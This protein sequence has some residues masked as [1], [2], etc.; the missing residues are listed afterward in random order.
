MTDLAIMS[1]S[2]VRMTRTLTRPASGEITDAFFNAEKPERCWA[3]GSR[4][5][6][7][8]RSSLIEYLRHHTHLV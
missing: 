8:A 6:A 3:V 4:A 5:F 2:S 7:R 1:S